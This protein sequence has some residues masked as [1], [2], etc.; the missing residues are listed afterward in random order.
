MQP[1][2]S[3]NFYIHPYFWL[4]LLIILVFS[5]IIS[6]ISGAFNKKQDSAKINTYSVS[7]DRKINTYTVPKHKKYMN[8]TNP[9]NNNAQTITE[10]AKNILNTLCDSFKNNLQ[11]IAPSN[12]TISKDCLGTVIPKKCVIP[13]YDP[14]T[15]KLKLFLNGLIYNKNNI[16]PISN[17]GGLLPNPLTTVTKQKP[18]EETITI[19]G[20][21]YPLRSVGDGIRSDCWIDSYGRGVGRIPNKAPCEPGQRDDGTSCWEDL[22]CNTYWDSCA[23]R[24]AGWLGGGCIGG[25]K[26][27]CSGCGCIKK[28]LFDRQFCNPDE[29]LYGSL[30]YPKCKPGY[31]NAGCCICQPKGG[32][33]VDNTDRYYCQNNGFRQ[34][35]SNTCIDCS[36]NFAN[37]D[38]YLQNKMCYSNSKDFGSGFSNTIYLDGQDS[39]IFINFPPIDISI[40][41]IL[42]SGIINSCTKFPF[43]I[44][45]DCE[46][47]ICN[48]LSYYL[49]ITSGTMNMNLKEVLLNLQPYWFNIKFDLSLDSFDLKIP[50]IVNSPTIPVNSIRILDSPLLK[51]DLPLEDLSKDELSVKWLTEPLRTVVSQSPHGY[52]SDLFPD[53]RLLAH[54]IH[55][56]DIKTDKTFKDFGNKYPEIKNK[57]FVISSDIKD[58]ITL[59]L[60]RKIS[61]QVKLTN[62]QEDCLYLGWT[63]EGPLGKYLETG[64][65][66]FVDIRY[67]LGLTAEKD[68]L[69][70]V[71]VLSPTIDKYVIFNDLITYL[72]TLILSNLDINTSS[73]V[74]IVSSLVTNNISKFINKDQ[75]W[76]PNKSYTIGENVIYND[77]LYTCIQSHVSQIDWPPNNTPALWKYISS[78][79]TVYTATI[80]PSYSLWTINKIYNIG[81]KVTHFGLNYICVQSHTSQSNWA[82]DIT[83][84]TLWNRFT[85]NIPITTSQPITTSRPILILNN[86][87]SKPGYDILKPGDSL[88]S[89]NKQYELKFQNDGNIVLADKTDNKIIWASSK[90]SSSPLKL[91][92]QTDGNLVAYDTSNKPFWATQTSGKGIGPYVLRLQDDRNLVLADGNNKLVWH[93][94]TYVRPNSLISNGYNTLKPGEY[95]E[96]SNRQYV[97]RFQNDGNI[98]LASRN[99]D[100]VWNSGILTPS[101]LK[102][103]MQT[104]GNLVAYKLGETKVSKN[105]GLSNAI[106]AYWNTETDGKK[107]IPQS[108]TDKIQ[109]LVTGSSGEIYKRVEGPYKLVLEDRGI[110]TLYGNNN[111]PLWTSGY[112]IKHI[113]T[114][115]CLDSDGKNIYFNKC[116]TRNDFQRWA[117][118][119]GNSGNNI[120]LHGKSGRCLDGNGSNIYFAGP[121]DPNNDFQNFLKTPTKNKNTPGYYN[122]IHKA[123]GKCLNG[124]TGRSPNIEKCDET[125][126]FQNWD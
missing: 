80:A 3:K 2:T 4:G 56:T 5:L 82:P 105:G 46:S 27:N 29:E 102:L 116:D 108:L 106:I 37:K 49:R 81:D 6:A 31:E 75:E 114:D 88:Q 69:N 86:L 87:T 68:F 71:D 67:R 28:N 32:P 101:P 12:N 57:N 26:T 95:L 119:P 45:L 120:I 107:M 43:D 38:A 13:S 73:I 54:T 60:A 51:L 98:V 100:I 55:N 64:K 23:S 63:K 74:N 15:G 20:F 34:G 44:S 99:N 126:S 72:F 9:N 118:Y 77:G 19:N 94:E 16:L 35:D 85:Q 92:L 103:V 91:V 50:L 18:C 40:N 30:C 62:F 76:I 84:P 111:F 61:K 78:I 8:I 97:L 53:Q 83:S 58:K 47:N 115:R 48:N 22:K 59:L 109:T 104:D 122:Y 66:P 121:C 110:C 11:I 90:L 14:I 33:R 79:Q 21:T 52:I 24:A 25:A 70:K 96:S 113:N 117:S 89:S 93:S 10:I 123:S 124:D 112:N 36:N 41:P 125:S 1:I 42:Q 65:S 7:K 39:N 17:T